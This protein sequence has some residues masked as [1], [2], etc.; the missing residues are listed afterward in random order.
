MVTESKIN[1]STKLMADKL[2]DIQLD[3]DEVLISFDL[4]SL[5]TNVAVL[6]AIKDCTNLLFSGKYKS[7]TG[8]LRDFYGTFRI[9]QLKCN[10]ANIIIMMGIFARRMDLRWG[11]LQLH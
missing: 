8:R 4:T 1:S 6:E 9:M 5:Y 7:T 10:H 3:D 11:V 2:S